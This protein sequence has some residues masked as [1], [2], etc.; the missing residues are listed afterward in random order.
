[1]RRVEKGLVP[2]MDMDSN[3]FVAETFD[4]QFFTGMKAACAPIRDK[5]ENLDSHQ[6]KPS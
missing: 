2:E 5:T 3:C 6:G 4:L 1:M